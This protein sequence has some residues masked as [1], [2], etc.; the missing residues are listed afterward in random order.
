[1][2]Y[3][4]KDVCLDQYISLK[5]FDMRMLI[6]LDT[7][8]TKPM[9]WETKHCICGFFVCMH[10][11][12]AWLISSFPWRLSPL[13]FDLMA[14][15]QT[16]RWDVKWGSGRW[17]FHCVCQS[18]HVRNIQTEQSRAKKKKRLTKK[19]VECSHCQANLN[20]VT[21]RIN[22]YDVTQWNTVNTALV[23]MFSFCWHLLFVLNGVFWS[24]SLWLWCVILASYWT[25]FQTF[26]LLHLHIWMS[27]NH[28]NTFQSKPVEQ[29]DE[30]IT[31]DGVKKIEFVSFTRLHLLQ[32]CCIGVHY[33]VQWFLL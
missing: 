13:R 28:R 10:E 20:W 23:K 22:L 24:C 15:V 29:H 27:E 9:F 17:G 3:S 18:V 21:R 25:A 31:T 4:R 2:F 19:W 14:L 8:R 1:M 12:E 7:Y 16:Y 11:K 26:S 5:H 6:L 32:D 30:H 33:N